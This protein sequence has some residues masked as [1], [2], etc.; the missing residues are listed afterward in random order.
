MRAD[1]DALKSGPTMVEKAPLPFGGSSEP[2]QGMST[3][4]PPLRLTLVADR[5]VVDTEVV[6]LTFKCFAARAYRISRASPKIAGIDAV[7]YDATSTHCA[8]Y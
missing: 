5:I 1:E 3:A 6:P 2:G 8:L 7:Q 4:I